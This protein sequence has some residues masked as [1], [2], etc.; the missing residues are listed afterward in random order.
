MSGCLFYKY[1]LKERL[2][3]KPKICHWCDNY[4]IDEHMCKR[5]GCPTS[6]V[7]TC[8]SWRPKMELVLMDMKVEFIEYN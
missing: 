1:V 6:N 7:A 8:I 3:K 5:T 2:M 4:D